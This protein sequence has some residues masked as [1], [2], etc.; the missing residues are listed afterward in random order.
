VWTETD[1]DPTGE[2]AAKLELGFAEEAALLLAAEECA[3]L[4]VD[5]EVWAVEAPAEDAPVEPEPEDSVH[6]PPVLKVM[7][8]H[9]V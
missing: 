8:T 6:L 2:V 3:M 7:A 4:D 9:L 5:P 1:A